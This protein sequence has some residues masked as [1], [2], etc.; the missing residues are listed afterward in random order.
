MHNFARAIIHINGI[1][2]LNDALQCR[3]GVPIVILGVRS[4]RLESFR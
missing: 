1:D 3:F 4:D 2:P